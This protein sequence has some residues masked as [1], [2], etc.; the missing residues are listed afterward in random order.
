[1][2]LRIFV[3]LGL[4]PA[5][6]V[7]AV[8]FYGTIQLMQESSTTVAQGPNATTTNAEAMPSSVAIPTGMMGGPLAAKRST[9][10]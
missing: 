10:D 1:M 2:K 7:P 4:A 6:L 9:R 5:V 3:R 8:L